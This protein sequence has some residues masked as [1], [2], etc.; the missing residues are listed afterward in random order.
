M[1]S[2]D[3][4]LMAYDVN[5]ITSLLADCWKTAPHL[6]LIEIIDEIFQGEDVGQLD[7]EELEGVMKEF[8]FNNM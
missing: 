6:S 5:L 7:S 3:D 1:N 2:Y 4:N 8:L